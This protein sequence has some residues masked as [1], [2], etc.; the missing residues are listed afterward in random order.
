MGIYL[1]PDNEGFREAID[2]EIYV[3]KSGL[4]AYT[5]KILGTEQKNIC[6]SRPRR[7]G[8]SMAAK[9]LSAYYSKGC[10]S[11][12][13]FEEKKIASAPSYQIHL[14]KYNVIFLN[15]Q[16]FLSSTHGVHIMIQS[17][18]SKVGAELLEE[19][20]DIAVKTKEALPE[21]L[22]Y[23]YSKTKEKFVFII[24][25][26]DCVFREKRVTEEGQAEYLDFLRNLL[27]DR[28]LR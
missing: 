19:Y 15:V 8:K 13:L 25:E 28:T 6:I 27:K 4:L 5:N 9:M 21:L 18:N 22:S 23:I 12:K 2:S 26:W 14:N 11:G 10:D 7:F 1:N 16:N 20:R 24:D 3:D 17:I